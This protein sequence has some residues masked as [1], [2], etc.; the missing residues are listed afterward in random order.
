MH[1]V[2]DYQECKRVCE[3]HASSFSLAAKYLPEE[4]RNAA[5]ALYA[6]CR[7]TDNILDSTNHPVEE[8]RNQLME[9]K[10]Q[11]TRAW[12]EHTH[13]DPIL[14]AFVSTCEQY[15][16]P[17]E[18]GFAL[19]EG[20]ASDL[21]VQR[22]KDFGEL[23]DYCYSAGAIPGLMIA[24]VVRAPRHVQEYAIALGVGMQLTNI[25]RDIPEDLQQGRI[26]LPLDELQA[27]GI[28]EETLKQGKVTR[29][30]E[31]FMRSQIARAREFYAIAER[32]LPLL[33]K[34]SQFSL[35]L[36]LEYYREIL[37]EMERA[38]FDVFSHRIFVTD[39]RKKE[40]AARLMEST[41]V[42]QQQA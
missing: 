10:N 38:G 16:I 4:K 6:F 27:F 9:W 17:R 19:I 1:R 8:K 41:R 30:F 2:I 11:L 24:F 23:Y 40:M 13:A 5:Y 33:E 29:E 7:H 26:Y 21:H 20:L 15:S 39:A 42:I 35:Q 12:E 32:G 36:C 14:H 22:F 3:L 28:S 25:L 18:L 34:D 31:A 37:G